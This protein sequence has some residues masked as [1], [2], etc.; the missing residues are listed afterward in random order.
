MIGLF[1]PPFR[2]FVKKQNRAFQLAIEDEVERINKEPN[3]GEEKKGNLSEFRVHKFKFQKQEYLIAYRLQ[4]KNI[5]FYMIGTHE[6][7]YRDLKRYLK[8]GE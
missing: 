8:E 7:F 1:K 3:I 2:K 5:V 4:D 6:N